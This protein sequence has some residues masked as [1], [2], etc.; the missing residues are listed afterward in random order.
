MKRLSKFLAVGFSTLLGI[1]VFSSVI[2]RD[3]KEAKA[4]YTGDS[5]YSIA[6][7]GGVLGSSSGFVT[8][9]T[10]ATVSGVTLSYIQINPSSG[11]LRGNGTGQMHIFNKTALP[12][13]ITGIKLN[14]TSASSTMVSVGA[15]VGTSAFT[16]S[17]CSSGGDA[18]IKDST[19]KWFTWEFDTDNAYYF[20]IYM[21]SSS[22][23]GS[24]FGSTIEIT[25][26]E[27]KTI[28]SVDF[29][30]VDDTKVYRVGDDVSVN[31]IK[32]VVNYSN[33]S[34]RTVTD[35]TGITINSG[36]PLST[37]GINILS[38]SYSDSYG[39]PVNGEVDVNAEPER[40]LESV[41][42]GGSLDKT[43]Y[44]AGEAWDLSGL[45]VVGNYDVAGTPEE[46]EIGTFKD[47]DE[48]GLLS[49]TLTPSQPQLNVDTLDIT[50]VV[51]D[52][53]ISGSDYYEDGIS[54]LVKPRFLKYTESTLT[55][56]EYVI[57]GYSAS[58][59]RSLSN[60]K[61]GNDKHLQNGESLT[62]ED[63]C[64]IDPDDSIIWTV[65]TS[66]DYFTLYSEDSTEYASCNGS[67]Q[68]TTVASVDNKAKWEVTKEDDKFLFE[69]VYYSNSFLGSNGTVGWGCYGQQTS[70]GYEL[71]LYKKVSPSISYT[72]DDDATTLGT[73]GSTVIRAEIIN[74]EADNLAFNTSDESILELVDHSD[75]TATVSALDVGEA[76]VTISADGCLDVEI[77]FTVLDHALLHRIVIT[78]N[79]D[80]LSYYVGETFDP[81]GLTVKAVYSDASEV[82]DLP[83][84]SLVITGTTFDATGEHTVTVSYTEEQ[85]TRTASFDVIVSYRLLTVSEAI[86]EIDAHPTGTA[87]FRI[88]GVVCYLGNFSGGYASDLTIA[89]TYTETSVS[90]KL[91]LYNFNNK[92]VFDEL[93]INSSL[94]VEAEMKKYNDK[95]ETFSI[96]APLEVVDY[97]S[98]PA[99]VVT[100]LIITTQPTKTTY[101]IDRDTEINLDGLVVSAKDN[102]GDTNVITSS[103]Y[104]VDDS[105]VDLNVAGTYPINVI[106]N[107]SGYSRSFNV[108]VTPVAV[109][110]L[111]IDH[112]ATKTHYNPGETFD[113][114]G[115]VVSAIY[116]T[117][118]EQVIDNN[119]LTIEYQETNADV[120]H[121]GDTRVRLVYQGVGIMH[122]ITVEESHI[123]GIEIT[124]LPRITDYE[125][126]NY[127]RKK[128]IV[129]WARYSDS[130]DDEKVTD[131]VTLSIDDG[132]VFKQSDVGTKEVTVSYYDSVENKTHTATFDI[133]VKGIESLEITSD[134]R[135]V[136]TVGDTLDDDYVI[137][138]RFSDGSSA[139]L[140]KHTDSHDVYYDYGI[141]APDMTTEGVKTVTLTYYAASVDFEIRV[142][143]TAAALQAIKD[144]AI[145]ELRNYKS[146]SD[147]DTD[148]WQIITNYINTKVSEIEECE[149]GYEVRDIVIA[150]KAYIDT[151]PTKTQDDLAAEKAAAKAELDQ[152]Y[153]SF[154]LDLYTEEG[155]TQLYGLLELYKGKI[156][157]ANNVTAINQWVATCKN[158]MD[159]VPTKDTPAPEPVDPTDPLKAQKEAA[160]AEI[161]NQYNALLQAHEYTDTNA[162][163]LLL[164][165]NNGIEAVK[166]ATTEQE[167]IDAQ[168]SAI[169]AMNDIDYIVEPEEV[170]LYR[171]SADPQVTEYY[172]GALFNKATVTVT[173]YF[174]DGSSRVLEPEEFTVQFD[175]STVG[176]NV[177]VTVSYTYEGVTKTVSYYVEVKEMPAPEAKPVLSGGAI[178]GIA[179]GGTAVVAAGGFAIY[180]FAIK[181]LGWK[182]LKAALKKLVKSIFKSKK[183]KGIE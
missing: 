163:L 96:N 7:T 57:T 119:L 167:I 164:A 33:G 43:T 86:D 133:V 105:A 158:A 170:T 11:Q 112:N 54:V 46:E 166:A 162:S 130:I 88:Q 5:P 113:T 82:L 14:Y 156:D 48:A 92:T 29:S 172:V 154:D 34:S 151:I 102:Y 49:Y 79:P 168:T 35:G 179:V 115:L 3:V 100:S 104:H 173:A 127:F 98:D 51:Y 95:Y 131:D 2:L 4:D 135:T 137:L 75:G 26:E 157:N 124:A 68:S 134:V 37:V 178:A 136:Y 159:A 50:V 103:E 70:I 107:D 53:S 27:N 149:F 38:V 91:N 42:I 182:A 24:A 183:K 177:K 45:M 83:L 176:E 150:A 84:S 74:G 64:V 20:S 140:T 106:H 129:V 160:I 56:G 97:E 138:A 73:G 108:T 132:Y 8:S 169:A 10:E 72:V 23:S 141:V 18:G 175:S 39:G 165:K 89:E 180:W 152:Y 114:T 59:T 76:T 109:S 9:E 1:G 66:G 85:V 123:T 30:L 101:F 32:A 15:K 118:E 120:I 21:T 80:K 44:V 71:T 16:T 28:S 171:I 22:T 110:S 36:T 41:T 25:F 65:A 58:A 52:G 17:N 116:N 126:G 19:N 40:T 181:K 77:V 111:R 117:G 63:D 78:S 139:E 174:S 147:Y 81:T 87:R 47:L 128:G 125:V 146:A 62:I 31:E 144:D 148:N 6:L 155:K 60:V 12:D 61:A 69:N 161:N 67:N 143:L 93:K 99:H 142:H 94:T 121:S 13:K 153:A 90:A 55:E 145:S 122:A